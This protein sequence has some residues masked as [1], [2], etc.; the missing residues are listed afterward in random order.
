MAI[1][2]EITCRRCGCKYTGLRNRCPKCG[3]PRINQPGRVPPTTASATPDTAAYER[4]AMN[5]RWQYIFAAVLLLAVILAVVVLVLS[6]REGRSTSSVPAAVS[7]Q[8]GSSPA[9]MSADLPTPSP[10]PDPTPEATPTPSIESMAIAFLN[11]SVGTDIT[12]SNPGEIEIDL[13]LNIYPA[14]DNPKVVWRSSNEKI[15]SVDDRGV[16]RVVGASPNMVTHATIIAEFGG[17]Q[18]YVTI[19]VP[20]IQ[21]AYLTENLFD[22]DTYADDNLE[23]DLI[24]YATPAPKTDS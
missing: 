4:G 10:S 7:Q 18:D 11:K 5:I 16:V 8:G 22:P 14:Q 19:Y 17:L 1:I 21:S 24:I 3:A 6:G 13:D 2:P 15:L 20:A 23:W 9:Y 12:L